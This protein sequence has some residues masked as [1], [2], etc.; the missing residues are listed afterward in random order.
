MS[1]SSADTRSSPMI[2]RTYKDA[3]NVLNTLQSNFSTID[4]V[5]KSGIIRNPMLIP[6]MVEWTRRIGYKPSDFNRLNIIHV[7]GTKGKG[8]VCSFVNSILSQYRTP[9]KF[10]P[11]A[12]AA[13]VAAD[14]I[15]IDPSSRS[16]SVESS[17]S[18]RITK[19]GLYVSPHL[20]TVRE[21]I[22]INGKPIGEE[23]F[24]R[25]FFEVFDRLD[26]S[27]SD[28]IKF[29]HM[30]AGVK[31]AYFRYLTLL[32]FHTFIS[33]GVDSAVFE[34]GIGGEYD[35]TNIIEHPTA[36]GIA[37]LGLDHT[38]ILGNTLESIAWNKS[39]IFKPDTP[40][41]SVRQ[42]DQAATN[43]IE[44]RAVEKKAASLQW[45]DIRSDLAD[46]NLGI[47][48]DFQAQNASLAIALCQAHLNKLGFAVD[49]DTLPDEFIRGLEQARWPGRCQ[50]L[51]DKQR[52]DL[53]WFIDGAHTKESIQGASH[54]FTTVTNPERKRVLLFNQQTRDPQLLLKTL[55][56]EMEKAKL[57]FSH[58]VFT[59]N[60]TWS[61]GEYSEDL[62]SL[63]TSAKQVDS[64]EVQ[65]LSAEIWNKLDKKS[66]KHIFH[67][68]QT[69][70]NFICS[71]EGPL[72]V[73]VCGSLHLV[74]G[75]LVVLESKEGKMITGL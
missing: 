14:A 18:P 63:N 59:T 6:E 15:D 13:A 43:M 75:F 29:P 49:T 16:N 3:V 47:N 70:I 41:F 5:R 2:R 10:V 26:K 4:A 54:W 11:A 74:G 8:S 31:P 57:M 40:C 39:G 24:A 7:T 69:S 48:G 71:L 25:Y 38:Q 56:H 42:P 36:C 21:R 60:V 34:V 50:I 30:T 19:I 52:K 12:A 61:S 27:S 32:A 67:D 9:A 46:I 73:F 62:V 28:P 20:K 45:V 55:Y 33:E 53:T 23:L 22:M 68:L 17:V 64:L 65:T 35:S 37:S 58:V 72:D 44:E 51:P 66:R 1:N